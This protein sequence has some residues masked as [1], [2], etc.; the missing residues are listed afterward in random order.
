MIKIIDLESFRKLYSLVQIDHELFR[1]LNNDRTYEIIYIFIENYM[2]QL[3]QIKDL[4][5]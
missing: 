2:I 5:F 4:N 3:L 1:Y